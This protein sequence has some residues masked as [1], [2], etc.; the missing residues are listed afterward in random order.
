METPACTTATG[1]YVLLMTR[2]RTHVGK[3]HLETHLRRAIAEDARTNVLDIDVRI[4][5][6]CVHLRGQVPSQALRDAVQS[7]AEEIAEGLRIE[8]RLEVLQPAPVTSESIK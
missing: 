5:D 4:I 2:G 8:N 6:G 3:G 1:Q 7:I